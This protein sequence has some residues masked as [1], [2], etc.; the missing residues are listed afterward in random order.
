[1]KYCKLCKAKYHDPSLVACP[2]DNTSLSEQHER[3]G[4]VLGSDLLIEDCLGR[5][6]MG[7]VYLARHLNIG[8]LVAIK[9]LNPELVRDER[10]LD[11][12]KREAL[13]GRSFSHPNAVRIDDLRRTE[14]GVF[15]MVMEYAPGQTL[16]TQ[17]T[18]RRR[19]DITETCAIL[20][21][22]GSVLIAAHEVGVIHRDVKPENIMIAVSPAGRF[23]VKLLDF[24]VAKLYEVLELSS[25][26]KTVLTAANEIVGTP[27][28]MSPE[29]RRWPQRD[30]RTEIDSRTDIYSLALVYY[31]TIAGRYP[32]DSFPRYE[33][34]NLTPLH[35]LVADVPVALSNVI[36]RAL[37]WDRGDRQ[38]S[39]EEFMSELQEALKLRD[40]SP[41]QISLDFNPSSSG[42]GSATTL[43]ALRFSNSN[44]E[45]YETS[46]LPMRKE[47]A[48]SQAP[49]PQP[50]E[51]RKSS[52][53]KEA[54]SATPEVRGNTIIIRGLE[55]GEAFYP[56]RFLQENLQTS[57]LNRVFSGSFRSLFEPRDCRGQTKWI[58]LTL[59]KKYVMVR[60]YPKPI[61][62]DDRDEIKQHDQLEVKGVPVR[63]EY[64]PDGSE[65]EC[66]VFTIEAHLGKALRLLF[67]ERG[68]SNASQFVLEL[69]YTE[70]TVEEDQRP[71]PS[72]PN[73][74]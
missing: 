71:E 30:G 34:T 29:Q 20:E 62:R 61:F 9:L 58:S 35:E 45:A 66:T 7:T 18:G 67:C 47:V 54:I 48:I 31:E 60:S 69:Y 41:D 26:E 25:L 72:L 4:H 17:L 57:D 32:F 13:A 53:V 38:A 19:F 46:T 70:K 44:R 43:S 39:I 2:S 22:I 24:G 68:G 23:L 55:P 33:S 21:P 65:D 49:A 12:F 59:E 52:E 37:S 6:G 14:D 10:V 16:A 36:H 42:S 11:R 3:I 1:M 40:S 8:D 28:Y 64:W 27:R 50:L 74:A 5:G 73:V 51:F 63:F 56:L 15:Y